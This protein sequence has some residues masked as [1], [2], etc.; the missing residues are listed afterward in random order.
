MS[1]L[2]LPVLPYTKNMSPVDL[3]SKV[4]F[5]IHIFD[6]VKMKSPLSS[7]SAFSFIPNTSVPFSGSDMHMPPILDP[8]SAPGKKRA[9]CSAFPFWAKLFTN[10]KLWAKYDKQNAGSAADNSSWTMQ[11]AIASMLAPPCSSATVT[12]RSPNS[13]PSL[14]RS[15]RFIFSARLYSRACGRTSF[16]AKARTISRKAACSSEGLKTSPPRDVRG[17]TPTVE[18]RNPP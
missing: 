11:A 10:S 13:E 4:P 8:S 3:E 12:P 6:P 2:P 9:F 15:G 5:V 18:G 16:S 1:P 17:R 7:V 14:R